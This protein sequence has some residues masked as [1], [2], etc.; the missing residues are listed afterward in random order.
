MAPLTGG[1]TQ[2]QEAGF[3]SQ[4]RP[5]VVNVSQDRAVWLGTVFSSV[6]SLIPRP[7][8]SITPLSCEIPPPPPFLTVVLFGGNGYF[9]PEEQVVDGTGIAL[10]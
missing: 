4:V 10:F 8:S 2:T 6:S 3:K 7:G 1:Q 5:A 9:I